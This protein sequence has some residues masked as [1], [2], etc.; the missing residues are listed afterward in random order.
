MSLETIKASFQA[1]IDAKQAL[2]NDAARLEELLKVAKVASSTIKVGKKIMLCGNGGSAAD[3]QHIAAE[4]IGR[5][6]KDRKSMAAIALTTDTSAL[7][8][9]GND[10]GYEEVFSRQVEGLGLSGDLL[11]GISTSGNSKNIIK[12]LEVAKK[13]GILTVAL[14]G[15]KPN[16]SMQA[17]ADYVLAAP[18]TNTARIQECHILMMH[19]LC[20]LVESESV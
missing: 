9:I 6:E 1:S 8:A 20:Q 19:T 18:C 5:F 16:G 7:T 2:I 10:Y 17:I 15:D 13:R 11:I 14:V 12:A 3:S 4:F